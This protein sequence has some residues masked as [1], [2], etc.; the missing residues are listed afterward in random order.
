MDLDKKAEEY[1]TLDRTLIEHY[2]SSFQEFI[3]EGKCD[4]SKCHSVSHWGVFQ[5]QLTPVSGSPMALDA[6]LDA[7]FENINAMEWNC[8]PLNLKCFYLVNY[9]F[10]VI[11]ITWVRF[12]T[13]NTWKVPGYQRCPKK[14]EIGETGRTIL[15]LLISQIFKMLAK[16]CIIIYGF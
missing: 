3:Y 14:G 7:W 2:S 9:L 15:P 11:S 13:L 5:K 10:F 12:A 8:P 1:Q 4:P 16:I 6:Q